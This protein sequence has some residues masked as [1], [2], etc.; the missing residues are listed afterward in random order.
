MIDSFG[1]GWN[2]ASWTLKEAGGE[3]VVAGPYTF[4]SGASATEVFAA[5]TTAPTVSPTAAPTAPTVSPTA[6]PTNAGDT[7]IPT[8]SPTA[9]PTAAPTSVPTAAPT[10][11]PTVLSPPSNWEQLKTRCE[12]SSCDMPGCT[13]VL[14]DD[15][16]MGSYTSEISFSGRMITLWGQ[17]K[18]LDASGS[19]RF[20]EGTYGVDG[21]LEVHDA[22]L[23]NGSTDVSE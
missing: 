9:A 7:H 10:A 21:L 12:S 22:V 18:V 13:I 20:F 6:A 1:D 5:W 16:I 4:S 14:S 23:Q 8:V 11:T 19:G 2:G 15:F 17:G 3:V